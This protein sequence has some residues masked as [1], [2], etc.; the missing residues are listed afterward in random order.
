MLISLTKEMPP[1][2]Q[3][4]IK[5]LDSW[6]NRTQPNILHYTTRITKAVKEQRQLGWGAF[7]EGLT[8]KHME[9]IQNTYY[10]STQ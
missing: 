10:E 4:I 3:A 6:R 2:Q 7:L 5:E 8:G 1:L 9:R